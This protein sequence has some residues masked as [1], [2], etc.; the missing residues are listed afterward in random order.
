MS[1]HN[2]LN[3]IHDHHDLEHELWSRRG[4]MQM[5]GLAG[6][7]AFMLGGLPVNVM[8]KS[9][10]SMGLSN[11]EN[12]RIL[13]LVRLQGGN[14]GLNTVIPLHDYSR[15]RNLRPGIAI[16]ENAALNL[17]NELG[18]HPAMQSAVDMWNEG[19]MKII[20]NVG[21]P[22]QNLSH[23]RSSDIWAT[24][25]DANTVLDTGFL[26]RIYD[27]QYPDFLLNPPEIPPA[28]QIGA[29]GNLAFIGN[30]NVNYAVTVSSPELLEQIAQNE[31]LY[32]TQNLP[33]CH[34]GQQLGYIRSIANNTFRYA[35][36][37]S[38]AYKIGMNG[39][40][41][42]GNFGNQLAIT[43]RLIKGGLK[44]RLYMVTLNG[45]DTHAG[46]LNAHA[47]LLNTLSRNMQAFFTDLELD[48]SDQKVL[49]LSFSEFGRRPQQNASMGTDHGAAA[50][51]FAFGPALAGNA[52][53]GGLPELNDLDQNGNLKYS[54]DFRSLYAS[55]LD[56]WLCLDDGISDM[57]LGSGFERLNLGFDCMPSS[58]F[59][60]T[61]PMVLR[62]Q[63]RYRD[64]G[65]PFLW[66][67]LPVSG[68][69]QI[70][71]FTSMGQRLHLWPKSS[72]HQGVHTIDLSTLATR[73]RGFYVYKITYKNRVYSGKVL[74]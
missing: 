39:V 43:A 24:A 36:V 12:E 73:I 17:S 6:G 61:H 23:F 4:F 14:D 27:D 31:G 70:E 11:N 16:A 71:L 68:Q 55:F 28:V 56:N 52:F 33:E 15:Y 21:Y 10:L 60:P 47:N 22:N 69:C 54:I 34:Y 2:K 35:K 74:M 65:L 40:E 41:Y 26:G 49:A 37:I 44:T 7:G 46:Q 67:E 62:H 72:Y 25:S 42:S 5:L 1:K 48:G 51:M 20:N 53:L 18:L 63:A 13:V 9:L 19:K 66:I 32:D 8:G 45:F 57:V 38:D 50:P 58:V 64:D 59:T 3:D 30:D 29:L